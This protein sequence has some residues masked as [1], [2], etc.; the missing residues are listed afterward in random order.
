MLDAPIRLGAWQP[1]RRFRAALPGARSRCD[2][3]LALSIN[4]AAVRLLLRAGGPRA[5][6]AVARRLGIADRLPD[7]ASIALGT[8]EVGLLELAAA[9]ATFF[10]GGLRVSPFGI[11][12]SACG[13]RPDAVA[14]PQPVAV[15]A[16]A[17]AADD[18]AD[19][20]R[21]GDA[22]APG[23]RPPSRAAVV[24]GKTGTTQ[25]YRDA[26]FVG[27]VGGRVIGVWLGN[28]DDQPMR[29]VSGGS[30]PALLFHRI[31]LALR[32]PDDRRF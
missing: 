11:D 19:A 26:W 1:A 5:V 30:L 3:A 12:G 16:P 27:A 24:A 2:Q 6:A 32:W 14:H 23:R 13:G 10:N 28:D 21:G 9:Y 8:G 22:R 20:G 15:I 7:N 4:T 17:L 25:D 31:A 18:G 29:G